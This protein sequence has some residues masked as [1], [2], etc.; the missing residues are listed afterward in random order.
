MF[1]SF[2]DDM[3]L[4]RQKFLWGITVVL[5]FIFGHLSSFLSQNK[6]T[7]VILNQATDKVTEKQQQILIN[8]QPHNAFTETRKVYQVETKGQLEEQHLLTRTQIVKVE[9]KDHEVN[10]LG[11]LIEPDG[12]TQDTNVGLVD[13]SDYFNVEIFPYDDNGEV[14]VGKY[15]DVM[16]TP[17]SDSGVSNVGQLV[18]VDKYEVHTEV[19][20]I[21]TTN[22]LGEFKDVEIY[23][24]DVQ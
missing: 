11:K 22:P 6:E 18:P 19:L 20:E 9:Y 3:I 5:A 4:S 2:L 1:I 16:E 15:I 17:Q 7:V 21:D 13:V 23:M 10:P 8:A 24:G 12:L 14:N